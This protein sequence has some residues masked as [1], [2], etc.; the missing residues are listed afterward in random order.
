MNPS[1]AALLARLS[2]SRIHLPDLVETEAR[3][4]LAD[5]FVGTVGVLAG[6][7]MICTGVMLAEF[8]GMV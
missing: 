6:G 5:R 2:L 3:S 4:S 1:H 8:W 7:W